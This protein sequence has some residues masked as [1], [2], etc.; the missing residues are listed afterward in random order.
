MPKSTAANTGAEA[1]PAGGDGA[2]PADDHE[3]EPGDDVVDVHPAGVM[4]RKGPLPARMRRVMAR[5]TRK[6]SH[7]GEQGEEQRELP[8]LDDVAVPPVSHP[9]CSPFVA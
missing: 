6:V 8:R 9:T 1:A 3:E 2:E 7:E 5:V 4:L